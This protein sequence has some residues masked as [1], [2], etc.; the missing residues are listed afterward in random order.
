MYN[1]FSYK[2]QNIKAR[3]TDNFV[4]YIFY[5]IDYNASEKM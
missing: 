2:L 3:K 1:V 4:I 5:I